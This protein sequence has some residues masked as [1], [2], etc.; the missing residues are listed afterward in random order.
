[1]GQT[2][3]VLDTHSTIWWTQRIELLS[4][5]AK[6]V[7]KKA[8]QVLIPTIVFWE[9]ALLIRRNRLRLNADIPVEKWAAAVLAIPRVSEVPLS[10]EIAIRADSLEMHPDPADRFIAATALHYQASLA[11]K[12]EL[13]RNLPWLQTV[14]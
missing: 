8:D 11:T 1:M 3:I 5:T 2:V 9:T 7:I 13:L 4:P 6:R 14:W 10:Y 12:D